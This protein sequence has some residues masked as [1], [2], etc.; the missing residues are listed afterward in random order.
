MSN[1]DSSDDRAKK[2]PASSSSDKGKK[3]KSKGFIESTGFR[4]NWLETGP[5]PPDVLPAQPDPAS[6]TS[7]ADEFAAL[8]E[9]L[10]RLYGSAAEDAGT[11]E[12]SPPAEDAPAPVAPHL[13]A[14]PE[15]PPLEAPTLDDAPPAEAVQP[16]E[17][18]VAAREST[19]VFTEP[20]MAAEPPAE[21]PA[22]EPVAPV[23][24]AP[25]AAVPLR[26][27]DV[28]DWLRRLLAEDTAP[29]QRKRRLRHPRR[30]PSRSHP[31][32]NGLSRKPRRKNSSPLSRSRQNRPRRYGWKKPSATLS[33][34]SLASPTTS[35]T[36]SSRSP[37]PRPGANPSAPANRGPRTSHGSRARSA[38]RSADQAG[39]RRRCW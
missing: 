2:P 10:Q 12:P 31:R 11:Q 18:P 7:I 37:R 36:A 9:T 6:E 23:A 24:P 39:Y 32:P 26:E 16:E 5:L 21:P 35:P 29:P 19:P 30:R 34:A 15:A 33:S 1:A 8:Q 20:L 38:R 27:A 22:P 25:E 13:E 3:G 17:A 28:P 4:P 14:P